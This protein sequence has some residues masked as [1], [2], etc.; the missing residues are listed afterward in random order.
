MAKDLNLKANKL[1]NKDLSECPRESS[2]PITTMD[3][4]FSKINELRGIS[5]SLSITANT[6]VSQ[7]VIRHHCRVTW[8]A[9]EICHSQN[10]ATYWRRLF[11][12]GILLSKLCKTRKPSYRWQ[13]AG[14]KACQKLL[15]FDVLTKSS[16]TILAYL[17]SFSCCCVRN[18]RNPEK[19]S[20]NSN[21]GLEFKV[22][23]SFESAHATSY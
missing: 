9:N 18:L 17:H 16:L 10:I 7:S 21:I 20:E 22:L 12:I 23:V 8:L 13:T 14:A 2:R 3:H 4:M 6:L 19:F 5:V 1:K 11:Q 15:Q